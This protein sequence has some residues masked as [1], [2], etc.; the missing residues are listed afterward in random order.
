MTA[1]LVPGRKYRLRTMIPGVERR[2]REHVLLF[3]SQEQSTV[4]GK[5]ILFFSARPVAGTQQI[6]AD[7][8]IEDSPV[9]VAHETECYMNRR[10][11]EPSA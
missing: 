10:P 1:A 8:I 11:K 2:P 4:A 5:T 3:M 9:E 7:W 6:P